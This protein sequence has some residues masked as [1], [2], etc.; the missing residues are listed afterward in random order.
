MTKTVFVHGINTDGADDVF[1]MASVFEVGRTSKGQVFPPNVH[2]FRYGPIGPNEARDL[3][4]LQQT[5][6]R[7]IKEAGDGADLVGHSNGCR[8]IIEA[9]RLGLD[10]RRVVLF[11]P[12]AEAWLALPGKSRGCES[13]IVVHNPRDKAIRAGELMFYHPFGSMGREGYQGPRDIRIMN[14]EAP[15][16]DTPGWNKHSGYFTGKDLAVWSDRVMAWLGA[17]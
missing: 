11:A 3:E 16:L 9:M 8:V 10:A 2:R 15:R 4:Y 1:Q 14:F 12:A 5:A 17:P 13:M 7:L 6:L